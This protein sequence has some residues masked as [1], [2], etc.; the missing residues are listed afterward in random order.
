MMMMMMFLQ[1]KQNNEFLKVAFSH[2][3][4]DLTTPKSSLQI[5]RHL[6]NNSVSC[7]CD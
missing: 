3:D 1:I 4:T 7:L 6:E 5:Q 2:T